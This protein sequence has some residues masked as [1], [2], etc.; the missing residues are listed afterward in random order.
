[1]L[2]SN[3]CIKFK[4]LCHSYSIDKWEDGENRLLCPNNLNGFEK[5]SDGKYI[6]DF[7]WNHF[8]INFNIHYAQPNKNI[9]MQIDGSPVSLSNWQNNNKKPIKMTLENNKKLTAKDGNIIKGFWTVTVLMK[10]SDK[11]NLNFEYR[12]SLYNQEKD[13]AIWEREPNRHLYIILNENENFYSNNDNSPEL[14]YLLKNSFL[15]ILDVNFVANLEFNKIGDKNIYIGPYPQSD[16][17][18]KIL[19]EKGIDTILNLQ[20]DKDFKFRQINYQLQLEQAKT[21]Q[22]NIIRYPIEDFNQEDLYKH[23]KGGGDLLNILLKE[24]KRVYV[25]CTAGMSRSAAVVIIYLVIYKN[26]TVA[27]AD[28]YCK[29]YRPI[30]CPNYG[31]INRVAY[32]YKPGT[33]I[34]NSYMYNYNN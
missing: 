26:Y 9:Y 12:Y 29:K 23:L 14:P 3:K 2:K 24:G 33:E 30:I 22:I 13:M 5:T 17:D 4:F 34:P 16:N 10:T 6:L 20:S 28:N 15:E 19:A 11:K 21:Y 25:H 18:F 27:Q 31:V 1:M 8:K 32:D 7:V